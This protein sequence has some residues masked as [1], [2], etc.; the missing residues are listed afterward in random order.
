MIVT[1]MLSVEIVRYLNRRTESTPHQWTTLDEVADNICG[2]QDLAF[3]QAVDLARCRGWIVAE[4]QSPSRRACLTKA[5]CLLVLS[6]A[7]ASDERATIRGPEARNGGRVLVCEDNTLMADVFL[8]A[9]W[10]Q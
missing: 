10:N 9:A 3:R 4:G 6:D 1:S 7:G 5:G 2:S 8:R